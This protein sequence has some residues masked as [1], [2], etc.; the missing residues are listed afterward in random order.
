[1]STSQRAHTH[2]PTL[3]REDLVL[4]DDQKDLTEDWEES[5]ST[6]FEWVGMAGLGSQRL[7]AGDRC[8]PYISVYEPPEPSYVGDLSSIRWTGFITSTFLKNVVDTILSP[9]VPSPSFVSVTVHAIPTSPITYL[10]DNT[11]AAPSLRAPR[12]EAEDTIS[13]VYVREEGEQA[14]CWWLWAESV[15]RWD[16]RWG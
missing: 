14:G 12:P 2:I 13:L 3:R 5:V 7:S 11:N 15:G 4:R 16:K 8:D 6:L 10:P 9:N 1:M